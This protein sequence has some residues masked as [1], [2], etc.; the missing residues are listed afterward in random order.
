MIVTEIMCVNL[1]YGDSRCDAPEEG[2]PLDFCVWLDYPDILKLEDK[3]YSQIKELHIL[4]RVD[5]IF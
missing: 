1:K 3:G 5:Y 2:I 4:R